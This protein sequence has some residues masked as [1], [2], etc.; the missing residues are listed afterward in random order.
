[1]HLN[2]DGIRPVFINIEHSY[3]VHTSFLSNFQKIEIIPLN[4]V[5]ATQLI[6][7]LTKAMLNRIED[8]ETYKNH[9][10]G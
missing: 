3:R 4:R 8:I 9:R 10:Y 2:S 1:M 6:M 7:Q 5:E